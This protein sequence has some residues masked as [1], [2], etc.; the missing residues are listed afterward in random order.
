[1]SLSSRQDCELTFLPGQGR[2]ISFR[3]GKAI[4][5]VSNQAEL[6]M[7]LL[8]QIEGLALQLG[9]STGQALCSSLLDHTASQVFQLG[10]T[11][12]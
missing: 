2:R 4:A 3:V 5:E 9:K 10:S 6:Y 12:E 7:K 1:M 8:S 11:I